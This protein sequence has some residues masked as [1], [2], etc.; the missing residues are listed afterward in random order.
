MSTDYYY[1]EKPITYLKLEDAGGHDKLTI[2]VNHGLTGTLTLAKRETKEVIWLFADD[3]KCPPL[4]S[5]W[6]AE[7]KE[8]I[9][10]IEDS[11]LP[12]ET[13]VISGHCELLTVAQV[14]ARHGAK[15]KDGMPTESFG[16]EEGEA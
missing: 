8:A 9:I 6:N 5:H 12:D 16:Y 10:T 14:K 4:H 15:R 3:E 7:K 11:T 1:L 13:M 2:W